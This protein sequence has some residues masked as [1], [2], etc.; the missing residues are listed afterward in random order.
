[1]YILGVVNIDL[2][3]KHHTYQQTSQYL[4]MLYSCT[5]HI[6][7]FYFFLI[8]L[9]SWSSTSYKK[10]TRITKLSILQY[11]LIISLDL[12]LELPSVSYLGFLAKLVNKEINMNMTVNSIWGCNY[13]D[14][15]ADVT[16]W[17][18]WCAIKKHIGSCH[19]F[20]LNHILVK[21]LKD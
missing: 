9:L 2:I 21:C 15:H 20:Q 19:K 13:R 3:L 18:I 16:Y 14:T 17:Y 4:Y 1:M 11:R 5:T 10:T 12:I 6:M 7:I 8:F